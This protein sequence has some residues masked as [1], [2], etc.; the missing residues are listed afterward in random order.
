[1]V[2]RFNTSLEHVCCNQAVE[3]HLGIQESFFRG[4]TFLGLLDYCCSEEQKQQLKRRHQL[5]KKC[6]QTGEEQ[7]LLQKKFF[8][9]PGRYLTTK[10]IPEKD[11]YGTIVSLLSVTHDMG[12][13]KN[14]EEKL[15]QHF[16][17]IGWG[18]YALKEDTPH[19]SQAFEAWFGLRTGALEGCFADFLKCVHDTDRQYF[20]DI[21]HAIS[22]SKKD[23][24][25]ACRHRLV[26]KEDS[27]CRIK[28]WA[29]GCMDQNGNPEKIRGSAMDINSQKKVWQSL[30]KAR[31]AYQTLTELS[32]D[33]IGQADRKGRWIFLNDQA[34][35]FWDQSR[36]ALLGRSLFDYTHA[37]DRKKTQAAL[38]EMM[39]KGRSVRGLKNRQKTPQGWKTVQWNG[40]AVYHQ[41]TCT[42][43]QFI[44]KDIT[45]VEKDAKKLRFAS[46]HDSLTGLYNRAYL[47]AEIGR[48]DTARQMPVSIIMA[49]LNGL[50][51]VND[52]YGYQQGDQMIQKAA[53]ILKASCR[54][55]DIVARWGGDEFIIL[56][57]QTPAREAAGICERIAA[58]CRDACIQKMPISIALGYSH[59]QSGKKALQEVLREAENLMYQHKLT[60]RRSTKSAALKVLLKTVA[61]KS[62]ENG[63]H[64]QGMQQIVQKIGKKLGLRDAQQYQLKLLATLHDVGKIKISEQIL[65]KKGALSAQDWREVKKHPEIGY[66]IARAVD[67][68]AMVAEEILA[69]HE[70]WDGSGYPRALKGPDI[71]L[72]S[73]MIAIIDAYQVMRSGRPY[74]KPLSRNQIVKELRRCA[75][76]QFDPALVKAF[77]T[78]L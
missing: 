62:Y 16:A 75:G 34:C 25:F 45:Q 24:P 59:K 38:K 57:P 55:E 21:H 12:G 2:V 9:L 27:T 8:P 32:D 40:A 56:L 30:N 6:L 65:T 10:I 26:K 13:Q 66:R 63:S 68:F 17:K 35:T 14:Q 15:Q 78:V 52:S 1:M 11:Q 72:L 47:E 77:L 46:L 37:Q 23:Q 19:C 69:H 49:D 73:R 60:E 39:G 71:P 28:Q 76:T 64:I 7:S 3:K 22:S 53:R 31:Q 44:G 29:R 54:K 33:I 5:L 51:L 74:K 67:D 41:G 61:E 43:F 42:G 4:K 70:R 50:K 48:L 36:D 58:G 20:I 18:E